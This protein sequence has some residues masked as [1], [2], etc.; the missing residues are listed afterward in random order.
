LPP[1]LHYSGRSAA[2]PPP[3]Y[4]RFECVHSIASEHLTS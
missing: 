4:E 2:A 1:L 3:F